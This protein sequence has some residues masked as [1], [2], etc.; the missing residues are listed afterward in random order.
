[1][2]SRKQGSE[3]WRGEGWRRDRKV[4]SKIPPPPSPCHTETSDVSKDGVFA[5]PGSYSEPFEGRA[6]GLCFHHSSHP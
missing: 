2:A 3:W 1:M 5:F 4:K 6:Q